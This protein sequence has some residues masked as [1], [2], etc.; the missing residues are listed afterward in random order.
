MLEQPGP[1]R[2]QRQVEHQQHHVADEQAGEQ[3]PD[4]RRAVLEQQRAG[5]EAVVLEGRRASPPRSRW[6]GCRGRAAAPACRRPRRCWPPR[7]RRRPRW[8]RGRTPR[9]AG[10]AS[11]PGSRT[12]RWASPRRRP[13]GRRTGSRAPCRAARPATSGASPT[14]S[15][16]AVPLGMTSA[17]A[18]RRWAAIHSASPTANRP[19]RR[20]RC[21]CRSTARSTPKVSRCWPVSAS[22]PMRPSVSP[23][24]SAA[25][26]R[27]GEEPSTVETATKA[28]SVIAK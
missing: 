19:P 25:R 16:T 26:P 2:R 3:R 21:R 13:A 20:R 15:S 24:A 5:L 14:G 18:W 6:S 28:S 10:S 11:S 12:G 1:Q 27:T 17:G 23:R 22:M 7:D 8:R 9:G 4:Q